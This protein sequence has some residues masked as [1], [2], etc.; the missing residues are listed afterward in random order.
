MLRLGVWQRIQDEV[1]RAGLVIAAERRRAEAR[2]CLDTGEGVVAVTRIVWVLLFQRWKAELSGDPLLGATV[3]GRWGVFF[4]GT[5]GGGEGHPKDGSRQSRDG[6]T[7]CIDLACWSASLRAND[8]FFFN[9]QANT[10]DGYSN[11]DSAPQLPLS[12][13]PAFAQ[14]QLLP[15]DGRDSLT[16]TAFLPR[17]SSVAWGAC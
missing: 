2:V 9:L 6:G 5:A 16:R 3:H 4:R 11:V 17:R 7:M 15:G 8:L 14:L 12:P 10:H 13:S 1:R